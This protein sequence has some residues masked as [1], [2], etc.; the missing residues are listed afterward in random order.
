MS[1]K[2][3]LRFSPSETERP[4]TSVSIS[5][6]EKYG[7]VI[8]YSALGLSEQLTKKLEQ[9]SD[10]VKKK[11]ADT[12]N[13]AV[14]V[15][16]E[17]SAELGDDFEVIPILEK[18]DPRH[19]NRYAAC[20]I[21]PL[22]PDGYFLLD[23]FLYDA[24]FIPEGVEPPPCDIVKQPELQVYTENFGTRKGDAALAAVLNDKIVGMAWARIMN[25]YGHI[26]DGTPSVAISVKKNYRG[27]GIG[28]QLMVNLLMVL[29]G[30]G[31]KRVSL[32]VQRENHAAVKLYIKLGFKVLCIK[33]DEYLMVFDLTKIKE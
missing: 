30:M 31:F 23:G 26:D 12:Y 27:G 11:Y 1:E 28:M 4:I 6:D 21:R 32:A 5:A 8:S 7:E 22:P 10:M 2:F 9:L 24:I 29:C 15:C 14:S 3:I 16:G 17:L 13:Y 19:K 25:D 18:L 33:G 20:S